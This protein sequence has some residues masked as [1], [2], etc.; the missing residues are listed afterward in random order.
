MQEEEVSSDEWIMNYEKNMWQSLFYQVM[1]K[2]KQRVA[3]AFTR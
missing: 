1:L 3:V 2:E